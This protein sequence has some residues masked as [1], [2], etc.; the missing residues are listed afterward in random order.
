MG[1][2]SAIA[3]KE[4]IFR[5]IDVSHLYRSSRPEVFCKKGV[6]R[7]FTKFKGK[8]LCQSFFFNKVAEHLWCLAEWALE[9]KVTIVGTMRHDRKGIPKELKEV[10]SREEK[11]VIFIQNDKNNMLVSYFDKK[12]SG[13]KNVALTT[14]HGTMKVTN[15]ERKKTQVHV[16]YDHTKGG[17]DMVDLLS[18]N[19][20]TRMKSK[21]W[22]LNVFAFI[23]DSCT[24]KAKAI[25]KDNGYQFMNFE[26]TYLLGKMLVLPSL[27]R[28]YENS[29]EFQIAIVNEMRRV[30]GIQKVSRRPKFD[31]I[32]TKCGRC[33]KCVEAVVGCD[34]YKKAGEKLIIS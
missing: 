34:D 18:T 1:F 22:P 25:L 17:V 8:N 4:V 28:R 32:P 16:M 2:Q 30:L 14:M 20:S 24:S 9:K 7:N 6:L 11:S 31:D 10:K 12:K 29:N 27:Q 3:L 23:L 15:D 33:F 13:K 26:F 19:H 21:R 5:W